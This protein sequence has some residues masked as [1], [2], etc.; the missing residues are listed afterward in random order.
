MRNISDVPHHFKT[1]LWDIKVLKGGKQG[2]NKKSNIKNIGQDS[3]PIH[4]E[5]IFQ[6]SFDLLRLFFFENVGNALW[7]K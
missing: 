4:F 7:I 2:G 6:T 1:L 3:G 5:Y